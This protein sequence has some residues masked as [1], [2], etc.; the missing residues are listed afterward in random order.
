M[1]LRLL[2]FLLEILI[3]VYA[4]SSPAFCMIH[5]AYKLIK[6]GNNI[7]LWHTPFS[8]WNQSVVP[9]PVL[10]VVSWSGY[11][12][13]RRQVRWSGIHISLRIFHYLLWS[14]QRL[15]HSQWSRNTFFF[16][17]I[18]LLFSMIK[19]MFAIWSL[20]PLPFLNSAWT[21]GISWFTNCWSLAWRIL[22]IT[23]LVCELS[24]IVS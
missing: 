8:I 1:Y 23:L 21:F 4:S 15:S 10:T 13:L 2:L 12:F 9:C 20:V 14:T 7:Q 6:Q 3:P 22:S 16:S 18:L 24:T 17:R 11:R 19:Q 5:P